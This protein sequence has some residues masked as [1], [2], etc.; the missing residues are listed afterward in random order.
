[1]MNCLCVFR[2]RVRAKGFCH[3][4]ADKKMLRLPIMT[5][6]NALIAFVIWKGG[7]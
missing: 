4:A 1:M 7:Q 5:E 2:V 3:K 6:R